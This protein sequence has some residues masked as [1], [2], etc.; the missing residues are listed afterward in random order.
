[1]SW[2]RILK[3][4][5]YVSCYSA[6]YA[7]A[8]NARRA[9]TTLCNSAWNRTRLAR[10]D[11]FCLF[12]MLALTDLR[13]QNLLFLKS[14]NFSC[15]LTIYTLEMALT[16]PTGLLLMRHESG[17]LPHGL[18]N[19][20]W[21]LLNTMGW[22]AMFNSLIS[23]VTSTGEIQIKYKYEVSKLNMVT[24]VNISSHIKK[25]LKE[26]PLLLDLWFKVT[27]FLFKTG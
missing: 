13:A 3:S 20:P 2:Q 16:A 22:V 6:T 23:A 12:L 19:F 24:A 11:C 27:G 5:C 4:W 1:M 8:V 26:E 25:A 9:Y 7:C 10:N 14:L 15:S 21:L 17:Y 18:V